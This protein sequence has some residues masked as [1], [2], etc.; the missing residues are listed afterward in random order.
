M[1]ILA[2]RADLQ[3]RLRREPSLIPAFVEEACRID[4]PFRG[5]YRRVVAD[6]ELGD[7]EVPAGS[8]LV[9][10]WTA[11]NRDANAF[12]HPMTLTSNGRTR[13]NTW[14]SAGAYTCA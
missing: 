14:A 10:A 4:P 5:H 11:A 1:R 6:A 2:E 12:P 9:L 7:V 13:V 3:D 8:T